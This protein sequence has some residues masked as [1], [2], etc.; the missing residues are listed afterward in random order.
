MG[1]PGSGDNRR[2]GHSSSPGARVFV[3]SGSA[4]ERRIGLL[5]AGAGRAVHHA[6]QCERQSQR[7]GR[8]VETGVGRELSTVRGAGRASTV[9]RRGFAPGRPRRQHQARMGQRTRGKKL[10]RCPADGPRRR[11]ADDAAGVDEEQSQTPPGSDRMV[12]RRPRGSGDRNGARRPGVARMM[13][14][15]DS[16]AREVGAWSGPTTDT[17]T[18][19]CGAVVVRNPARACDRQRG[20]RA[21]TRVFSGWRV[22]SV[23]A[24]EARSAHVE[25]LPKP[26]RSRVDQAAAAARKKSGV[27]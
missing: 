4:T 23:R 5:I 11:R 13:S 3:C 17:S 25:V 24:T 7:V 21:Y 18:R 8:D 6:P 27:G 9:R 16:A 20:C 10:A 1:T 15:R 2:S 12:S 19:A 22:S 14:R 26:D